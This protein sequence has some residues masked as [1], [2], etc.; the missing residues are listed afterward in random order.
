MI[1][2]DDE[3]DFLLLSNYIKNI[4]GRSFLIDWC[5]D[6]DAA[7]EDMRHNRHDLYFVDYKLG[8]KTGLDILR[9]AMTTACVEPIIMLTGMG[10]R[11]LDIAALAAGATDYLNKSELTTDKLERSIRYAI[12]RGAS[13]KSLRQNEK[14]FRAIFEKSKDAVFIADSNF[15]FKETNQALAKLLGHGTKQIRN[16]SM[17]DLIADPEKKEMISRQLSSDAEVFDVEL[18]L[19]CAKGKK[20]ESLLSA[21]TLMDDKGQIYIQGIIHDITAL[22]RAERS[23]LQSEKLKAANRLFK[24]I[25]HE[26]RNPL[27]NIN[28]SL[29]M[30]EV[31]HEKGSIKNYIDIIRRSSNRISELITELLDSSREKEMRFQK[32][33]VQEIFEQT[34]AM[35]SDRIMLKNIQVISSYPKEDAMVIADP[36][37]IRIAILNIIINAIEAISHDHGNLRI[38]IENLKKTF[39]VSIEDNG[40]GISEEN[41]SRLFEPFFTSKRNGLGL[42]LASTFAILQSHKIAV[43]VKTK[44]GKGTC[45]IL[46]F[47][48]REKI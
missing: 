19:T 9:E 11:D 36:E 40:T 39:E 3:D 5:F 46:S 20:I 32:I 7:L 28:I 15:F 4:Q 18:E 16:L 12:E 27:T 17:Y 21:S 45:F 31:D 14:K 42:G 33:S 29:D 35:A 43:D 26:V 38:K 13:L 30:L 37:K 10:S 24:I 44:L 34:L 23:N 6:H 41:L 22:R 8:A 25:A 2:D 47:P 48:K 1:I